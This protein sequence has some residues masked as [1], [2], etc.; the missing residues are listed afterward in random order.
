[1]DLKLLKLVK[2][3]LYVGFLYTE[4]VNFL[5]LSIHRSGSF[6]IFM[7]YFDIHERKKIIMFMFESKCDLLIVCSYTIQTFQLLMIIESDK[8]IINIPSVNFKINLLGKQK[9]TVLQNDKETNC[10][11][12]ALAETYDNAI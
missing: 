4:I 7:T 3:P 10:L 6:I 12:W 2:T 1:M 8:N 5:F 11:K 9:S